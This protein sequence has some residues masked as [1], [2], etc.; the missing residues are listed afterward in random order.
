MTKTAHSLKWDIVN[1]PMG[2]RG[3]DY[4]T[5]WM[6]SDVLAAEGIK[7]DSLVLLH[8]A[9]IVPD[10]TLTAVD[11]GPGTL[12]RYYRRANNWVALTISPND[13]NPLWLPVREATVS[14][15]FVRQVSEFLYVAEKKDAVRLPSIVEA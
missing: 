4:F 12:L 14:G 8:R 5:L 1:L 9:H 3:S 15:Y 6:E 10:G 13:P 7:S 11:V 2:E